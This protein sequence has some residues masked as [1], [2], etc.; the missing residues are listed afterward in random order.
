MSGHS[1]AS[2]VMHCTHATDESRRELMRKMYNNG[3]DLR[4]IYDKV[5]AKKMTFAE[6]E[7]AVK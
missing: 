7:K 6:F 3:T 1:D 4:A 2:M 5:R